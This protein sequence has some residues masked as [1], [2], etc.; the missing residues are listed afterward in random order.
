MTANP[1][2]ALVGL[3]MG[4]RS[5]WETMQH[6]AQKLEALGVPFEVRVVSAHRTPDVLFDYAASAQ[7]RGPREIIAGAGRAAPLPGPLAPQTPVPA[8]GWPV[9][10]TALTRQRFQLTP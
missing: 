4:S 1:K 10:H 9:P 6:A 2:Q 7:S 8:R 5:D 3:V